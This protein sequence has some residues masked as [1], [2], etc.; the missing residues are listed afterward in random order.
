MDTIRSFWETWGPWISLALIP[1]LIT[2]LSLSPKTKKYATWIGETWDKIK[3]GIALFSVATFKDQPGTF[4]APLTTGIKTDPEDKPLP[5]PAGPGCAAIVFVLMTSLS[6]TLAS[7]A[8]LSSSG[9]KAKEVVIDCTVEAVKANAAHLL[10]IVMAIL[11]GTSPDWKKM[12]EGFT[13]E[14]GRDA[15][16]CALNNAAIELQAKIPAEG[17]GDDPEAT[18]AVRGTQKARVFI[19]EKDWQFKENL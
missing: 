13:K 10:P 15:V 8:W 2:G 16:A 12:L 4:K 7:C 3:P 19:A 1:T 6:P 9:S 14:L 18:K 17:P 5:P 11:T